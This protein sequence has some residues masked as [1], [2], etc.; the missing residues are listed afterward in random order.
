LPRDIR[1]STFGYCI[2]LVDNLIS[3]SFKRQHILSWSS[4][5]AEYCGI[6][7]IVSES[8]W[9][10]NLL[11]E[12]HCHVTTSTLVYCDTLRG[13]GVEYSPK[14]WIAIRSILND[15]NGS[16]KHSSF[17][18]HLVD[19]PGLMRRICMTLLK[20]VFLLEKGVQ[21]KICLSQMLKLIKL[22]LLIIIFGI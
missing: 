22:S 15:G 6:A 21:S 19:I 7:N 13:L 8:C 16:G 9:I 17:N 12:L 4:A 1:R 11:L 2:Y 18:F 20:I 10:R 5:K 14:K 3:W